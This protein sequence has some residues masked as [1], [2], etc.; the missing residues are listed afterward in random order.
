[1]QRRVITIATLA[2][3]V[4]GASVGT[5]LARR[6]PPPAEPRT[7]V[8]ADVHCQLDVAPGPRRVVLEERDPA[9]GASL[10]AVVLDVERDWVT[11]TPRRPEGAGDLQVDGFEAADLRWAGGVCG[12]LVPLVPRPETLVYGKVVGEGPGLVV[13]ACGREVALD[14]DGTFALSVVAGAPCDVVVERR[15]G[16]EVVRSSSVTVHP[17]AGVALELTLAA[18]P[19]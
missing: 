19:G 12:D 17:R 4:A 9:T 15:S 3:V 1:V 5:W 13:S 8:R 16:P 18:P 6:S 2:A 10:G 11:F 14:P 7:V